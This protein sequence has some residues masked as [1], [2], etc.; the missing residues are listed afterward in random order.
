MTEYELFVEKKRPCGEEIGAEKSV[1][2]IDIRCPD[3]YVRHN[4]N[5]P[6]IEKTVAE[7]G[8][9]RFVTGDGRGNMEKYIFT[10]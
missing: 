6:V 8:D 2:E 5:F 10:E 9:V 1:V 7:N 4:S 3:E